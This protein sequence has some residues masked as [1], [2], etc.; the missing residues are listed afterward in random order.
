MIS[1]REF[2]TALGYPEPYEWQESFAER[3][4]AGTSPAVVGVPTGAGKTTV[5]EALVWALAMQADR[6]AAERT[7]GVRTVW[8]IDRRILVDEVHLRASQLA[9][10]LEAAQDSNGNPLHEVAARLA[11]L[12]GGKPLIA[13]RWRGGV[14]DPRELLG[15]LQPQ[16]ITSTVAQIGSRLLFRGYG[17]APGSLPLE[18]GLAACDTTICLDEAHLAEP[19]RQTVSAI[20][21]LRVAAPAAPELPP[22]RTMTITATPSAHEDGDVVRLG[23]RDREQL[24]RRFTGSKQARLADAGERANERDR[25]ALLVER[26]LAHVDDGAGS[27]A[28][29]VNTVRRARA[30]WDGL[31]RSLPEGVDL[32]LLIGPQRP[33]DRDRILSAHRGKL[34]DRAVDGNRLVCVTTQTF[35]VGLD[36]DVEAMV[37]ESASMQALV[38]RLGR[39]NRSGCRKGRATIVRD[40]DPWLY[41]EH[42]RSAW[43][44][45]SG[46]GEAA[47]VDVSVAALEAAEQRRDWPAPPTGDYAPA[48]TPEVAE[49]LAQTWPRPGAWQEPDV[50]AYLSGVRAVPSADVTVCWRA[51]LR[52]ERTGADADEYRNLLLKAAPPQPREQITLSV[53]AARALI[54]ARCSHDRARNQA[55][56]VAQDDAD[57]DVRPPAARLPDVAGDPARVPFVVIHRGDVLRGT[58]AAKRE[59]GTVRPR[60]LEPGDV[61]VLPAQ[62]GGCDEFGLAPAAVGPAEDVAADLREDD[63]VAPVRITPE[64]LLTVLGRQELARRWQILSSRC[65]AADRSLAKTRSGDQRRKLTAQL[66]WELTEIIPGHPGLARFAGIDQDE[67]ALK[68]E[69]IGDTSEQDLVEDEP[70]ETEPAAS[71][72]A[73]VLV[74]KRIRH[75]DELDR[76]SGEQLAPPTLSDHALAVHAR[77][78]KDLRR[79]S[80]PASVHKALLLAA[81]AH[82]HGKADPR[83]QDYFH[84]GVRPLGAAPLAKSEFGAHD[85]AASR[86]AARLA[87]LPGAF[88]HEGA[89][90]AVLADAIAAGRVSDEPGDDLDRDL[91]YVAVGTHHARARPLPPLPRMHEYAKPPAAF[92]VDAAG[93]AG[94]ARGDGVEAFEGGAWVGRLAAVNRRYGAWGAAYLVGLLMLADRA[95]SS[96]GR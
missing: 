72:G 58:L 87:G 96:E 52:P 5:V 17:V 15:P 38:Q 23:Q 76:S 78:A 22:T 41:G 21:A 69:A 90:V 45:L 37:T 43:E 36:A 12:G 93:V 77:L 51:D 42:E 79:L 3:C 88:S 11:E 19:F 57:V 94:T 65:R 86:R 67:F 46:N 4:A 10:K 29:V 54:A 64:A 75:R 84:S 2:L 60:D 18:A 91:M 83:F 59:E 32:A 48:L 61:V 50:E 24:G 68:L 7:V 40:P 26:T 34:F 92:A 80:L 70:E 56:R 13:T 55:A 33:I 63:A 82:D 49:Q 95:V 85:S 31:K 25:V 8:A 9:D 47:E 6:P 35:E 73:W 28:C 16:I 81:R 39:L 1:F 20:A 89:S 44:W 27:V 30:V 14:E 74:P 53:R 62:V 66:V 71:D